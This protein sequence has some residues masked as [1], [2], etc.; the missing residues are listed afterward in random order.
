MCVNRTA[1]R[2]G[3]RL[4]VKTS[5]KTTSMM[6]FLILQNIVLRVKFFMLPEIKK[7]AFF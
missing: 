1:P 7:N 2:K 5:K 6:L 4:G 3:G